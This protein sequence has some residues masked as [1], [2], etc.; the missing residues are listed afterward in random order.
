[1][2]N[3]VKCGLDVCMFP[4]IFSILYFTLPYK[5]YNLQ[6][7]EG[8]LNTDFNFEIVLSCSG[9]L[10]PSIILIDIEFNISPGNEHL[11]IKD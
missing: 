4:I 1:M 6:A 11:T 8:K 9:I 2:F 3:I 5:N 7:S 10:L